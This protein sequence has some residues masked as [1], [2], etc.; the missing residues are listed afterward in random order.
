MWCRL[1]DR[2]PAASHVRCEGI[3]AHGGMHR[4]IRFLLVL[5]FLFLIRQA[6]SYRNA[7]QI[8]KF[9]IKANLDE[10]LG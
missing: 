6:S 7:N 8:F 4:L 10:A 9:S 1:T 3:S 2:I 5:T